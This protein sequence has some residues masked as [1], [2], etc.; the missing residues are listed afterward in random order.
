[1]QELQLAAFLVK[2]SFVS[3]CDSQALTKLGLKFLFKNKY[4]KHEINLKTKCKFLS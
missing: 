4:E 3:A 1:L 2:E